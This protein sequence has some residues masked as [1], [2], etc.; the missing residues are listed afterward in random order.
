MQ[1]FLDLSEMQGRDIYVPRPIVPIINVICYHLVLVW[2][3]SEELVLEQESMRVKQTL[4][5]PLPLEFV[6]SHS[7]GCYCI[8]R[9]TVQR[10]IEI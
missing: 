8:L 7:P 10:S 3:E 1:V 2:Y 6:Y 5:R 9:D 4:F